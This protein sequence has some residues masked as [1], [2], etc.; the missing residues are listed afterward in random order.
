MSTAQSHRATV[1]TPT[2]RLYRGE[3]EDGQREIVVEGRAFAVV[4][5]SFATGDDAIAH[6]LPVEVVGTHRFENGGACCLNCGLRYALAWTDQECS[7]GAVV[8]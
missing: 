6:A 1:T 4:E 2:A 7:R 3:V 5:L 8:R